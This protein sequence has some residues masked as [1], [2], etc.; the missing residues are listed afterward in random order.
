[1]IKT[2]ALTAYGF[3]ALP[4][5]ALTLPVYIFLPTFYAQNLGLGFATVGF[6]L[7]LARS[8]DV[9]SDLLAGILSDKYNLFIGRRKGWIIAGAPLLLI[10]AWFVLIPTQGAGPLYLLIWST[11]LYTGW[12]FMI[13]P[14]NA[15]GAE[16]SKDYNE[17]TKI[18]AWREGATVAGVLS[19]LALI[20]SFGAAEDNQAGFALKIIA[21]IVLILTPLSLFFFLLNVPEPEVINKKNINYKRSMR[22]IYEN[23]PFKRLIVAYIINGLANALPATLFLVFVEH[24]L[25][26]KEEAGPLLFIYF[27]CGVISVPFW[28]WLSKKHGK[29]KVWCFSMIWAC[30]FFLLVPL[31]NTGDY[32]LFL[33]ICIL[34][35][36]SLGADLVLPASMQA[37]VVDIDTAQS[38]QQRTGLYFA[39]WGM[40]TKISLALAAGIAFPLLEWSDMKLLVPLYALIPIMLKLISIWIMWSHTLNEHSVNETQERIKKLWSS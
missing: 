9:F 5:A 17:R 39:F 20:A 1:M 16:L 32:L 36:F 6:I 12:S 33:A 7:L 37:D 14:L 15:M 3:T 34:T 30:A 27:L 40:A 31:V 22:V 8:W 35:G 2:P 13:L 25:G 23:A 4:L 10:S 18:A 21:F 29:H 24:G 19:A 28:T 11:L 38:G 26:M